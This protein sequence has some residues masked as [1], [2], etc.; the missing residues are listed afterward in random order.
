MKLT[1]DQQQ[2]ML[3][4]MCNICDQYTS[5]IRKM[6]MN[7]TEGTVGM[8]GKKIPESIYSQLD[9]SPENDLRD[10][11]KQKA[12]EHKTNRTSVM[13]HV[14]LVHESQGIDISQLPPLEDLDEDLHISGPIYTDRTNRPM[15]RP[16]EL[17]REKPTE[18]YGTRKFIVT[19]GPAMKE[20][21]D[22]IHENASLND[23]VIM[24]HEEFGNIEFIVSGKD[25][26]GPDY[27]TLITSNPVFTCNYTTGV[28]E[29]TPIDYADSDIRMVLNSTIKNGFS[30]GRYF[31]PVH[32]SYLGSD[33]DGN[34]IKKRLEEEYVWLL[35]AEDVCIIARG[36]MS[37]SPYSIFKSQKDR[38]R[39]YKGE[40][41]D[42]WLRDRANY[43]P[44]HPHHAAIVKPD[45][46]I[47]SRV[48]DRDMGV[49]FA[50]C[51]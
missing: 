41:I 29:D 37:P 25:V 24:K 4:E 39:S 33:E 32:L 36:A 27:L 11:L 46:N 43:S 13:A 10:R 16:K 38:I 1:Y 12:E 47:K 26:D 20:D 42:W 48:A 18:H 9:I 51:I 6:V 50:I 19:T 34:P 35:S 31:K 23:I 17:W 30:A 49:M 5:M 3:L 44:F 21:I 14:E 22:F 15:G 2:H 40:E 28:S 45:G 7:S 8:T